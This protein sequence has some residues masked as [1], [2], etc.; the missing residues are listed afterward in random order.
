MIMKKTKILILAAALFFVMGTQAYS[1][2]FSWGQVNVNTASYE[3]L[4]MVPCMD[5][6]TAKDLIDL[7]DEN[8]PFTSFDDLL[9][10]QGINKKTIK[11]MK[12]YLKFEGKSDINRI[13]V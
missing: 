5:S 8:G 12:P 3:Q 10:V 6:V 11:T 2:E 4:K 13:A 1:A 7:R 9:K